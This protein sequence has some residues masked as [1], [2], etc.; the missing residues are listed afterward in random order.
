VLLNVG[1]FY[2]PLL[3]WVE[4][5]IADGFEKPERRGYLSV[6]EDPSRAVVLCEQVRR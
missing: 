6:T 4:R 1:G 2:D 5:A 3:A